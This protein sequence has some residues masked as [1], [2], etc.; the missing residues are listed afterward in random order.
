M[1]RPLSAVALVTVICL[2]FPAFHLGT[3]AS[4][5]KH[6]SPAEAE[7]IDLHIA[8]EVSPGKNFE[9]DIGHDLLFRLEPPSDSADTG[10]IIEIVPKSEPDD[11]PIEFSGIATPPYRTY[12]DR[13][14]ATVYGRSATEVVN[15]KYRT[16]FFVQSI[17]DEH[18]A[19]EVVNVALYPTNASDEEKVRAAGEQSQIRLGKGELRILKSRTGRRSDVGTI[20]W[21][22][23]EVDI[24]FSPG[25]TMANIIARVAHPQ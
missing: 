20:D 16:F 12:N 22:R 11:G 5:Q 18:R 23:F 25:L 19:E 6:Q 10:W 8:S 24:E 17:D 2:G 1:V 9:Q 21:L 4:A 15:L 3:L 13:Y 7:R 14:I